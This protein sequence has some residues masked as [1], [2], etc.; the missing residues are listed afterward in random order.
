MKIYDTRESMISTFPKFCT[1]A[2]V[3]VFQGD[4]SKLI[5]KFL[6]PKELHLIDIFEGN[7]C[8]GD[9]NGNNVVHTNLSHEFNKLKNY[10]KDN[11]SIFLHKGKSENVLLHFPDDYFDVIYIDGDH[12]YDGV[13]KDLTLAKA[14]VKKGGIISGHDYGPQFL[15]VIYAV[16]DFLDNSNLK[17][18]FK[19]QDI[20]PSFGIINNK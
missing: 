6:S 7:A 11:N 14:K 8:S 13:S 20:F 2:E 1:I 4:F 5:Y 19:T 9:K 12:S 10:F 15:S 18:D 3:G 16:N 17:L